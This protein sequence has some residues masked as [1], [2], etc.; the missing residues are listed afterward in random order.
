MKEIESKYLESRM[1]DDSVSL[2]IESQQRSHRSSAV[3][4]ETEHYQTEIHQTTEYDLITTA[5]Y[6]TSPQNTTKRT[7]SPTEIEN[8]ENSTGSNVDGYLQ[9]EQVT[10]I[11]SAYE[12]ASFLNILHFVFA[13]K[14]MCRLRKRK[15]LT[16]ND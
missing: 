15:T 12:R 14:Q 4:K 10:K 11:P 3:V 9:A 16:L 1:P 2:V 5:N 8:I 7:P 6:L 13:A